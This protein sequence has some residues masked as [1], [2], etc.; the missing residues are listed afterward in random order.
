MC[1]EVKTD[2][3]DVTKQDFNNNTQVY[4][5]YKLT[6]LFCQKLSKQGSVADFYE[7]KVNFIFVHS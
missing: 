3:L 6:T 5:D 1:N 7:T 2:E 4:E